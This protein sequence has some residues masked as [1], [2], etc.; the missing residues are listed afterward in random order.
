MVFTK[1]LNS[2]IEKLI[3][4]NG[5]G[6]IHTDTLYGIVG[7]AFSIIAVERIYDL[8]KRNREKP[9]IVLISALSDLDTFGIV[10]DKKTKQILDQIWPGPTSVI[11]EGVSQEYDYLT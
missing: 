5:V 4:K 11:F 10:I 7:S 1:E 9:L 8:K 2:E 6:I 3:K